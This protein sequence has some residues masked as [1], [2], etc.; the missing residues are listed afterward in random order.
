MN[1]QYISH[2]C[3]KIT[4]GN[5]TLITDPWIL[6][7]PVK[8]T[9]VWKFPQMKMEPEEILENVDFVYISHS[10]EDH[11]HIPS[12]DLFSRDLKFII[13]VFENTVL[14]R[15]KLIYN[16]LTE[17]GFN[18]IIE[19][20]PWENYRINEN[21]K[22]TLIPAAKSRY[23][24]W[25]NSGLIISSGNSK[26]LNM[27]DN[28]PDKELCIEL[29]ERFQDIDIAFIQTAGIS[30]YPSCF[31]MPKSEKRE[32]IEKKVID[33]S[34]QDL[35]MDIIKPKFVVPFAG[36]FGWFH[37]FQID[38]NHFSRFTPLSLYKH[39]KDKGF[40]CI[41][42][43]PSDLFSINSGHFK[44]FERI[45]WNN[46]DTLIENSLELNSEKINSYY[47]WLINS[48]IEDLKNKSLNR[49]NVIQQFYSRYEM[50]MTASISYFIEG[51]NS[52]F[53]IVIISELGLPLKL[54][55]QDGKNIETDQTCTLPEFIWASIIEGKIL[56]NNVQWLTKIKENK[57]F[58]NEIR[59]LIFWLG[60][61]IDIGS[62]NPEVLVDGQILGEKGKYMRLGLSPNS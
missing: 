39:I 25:E 1:I 41:P 43:E 9:S 19:L 59:D 31:E 8:A 56:W 51:A 45:N 61:H 12:I 32:K 35:I 44:T 60:Y 21:T 53:S 62:R 20:N 26:V 3:L 7:I 11:F 23:Y 6:D 46:Y 16:V 48:N 18:N 34:V 5:N 42:M 38:H 17:M 33:Y 15:G 47:N 55:I 29:K 4:S 57:R 30:T 52:N 49:L 2:A 13:P 50:E 14:N 28:V 22:C 37:S 24:D 36:D 58:S 27:N 54:C 40:N 10:H